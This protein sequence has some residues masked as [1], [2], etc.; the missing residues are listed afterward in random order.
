MWWT[1]LELSDGVSHFAMLSPITIKP[2]ESIFQE[3]D[4]NYFRTQLS[5]NCQHQ[6]YTAG[7]IL[8]AGLERSGVEEEYH[9]DKNSRI[10]KGIS[11]LKANI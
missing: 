8:I 2:S 6:Q 10:T 1:Q 5:P 11:P 9:R 4:L 7:T 3:I